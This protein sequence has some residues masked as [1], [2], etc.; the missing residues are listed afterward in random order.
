MKKFISIIIIGSAA[1]LY[2]FIDRPAHEITF[3]ELKSLHQGMTYKQVINAVGLP[4]KVQPFGLVQHT[5]GCMH[6]DEFEF[7]PSA[8]MDIGMT[9]NSI[10]DD[11]TP[12]CTGMKK[13]WINKSPSFIYRNTNGLFHDLKMHI[14]FTSRGNIIGF[15]FIDKGLFSRTDDGLIYSLSGR[16]WWDEG[17]TPIYSDEA[18]DKTIR[19][20]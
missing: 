13:S 7:T 5:I 16:L 6:P 4:D 8:Q 9:I 19:D 11:S 10:Y 18:I 20:L 12:C 3:E 14:E 17:I 2:F 1:L 15:T